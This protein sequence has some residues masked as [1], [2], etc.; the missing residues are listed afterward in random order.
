MARPIKRISKKTEEK[1]V[2]HSAFSNPRLRGI[3]RTQR[4]TE[5][6]NQW[7]RRIQ[8]APFQA[9]AYS[10]VKHLARQQTPSEGASS[11]T[12][13]KTGAVI[14]G[15]PVNRFGNAVASEMKRRGL[16]TTKVVLNPKN[17][18]QAIPNAL[19]ASRRETVVFAANDSD[20]RF[21]KI[22]D[23]VVESVEK[24]YGKSAGTR[25]VMM[26]GI[27]PNAIRKVLN[28]NRSRM[29]KFTKRTFEAVQHAATIRVTTQSGTD[30]TFQLTPRHRWIQDNGVISKKYW[31]NLP[32]G[33]V[34][35][36]PKSASGTLVLDGVMNNV[37]TLTKTPLFVS[38]QN[39]RAD[40]SSVRC[41]NESLRKRFLEQVQKDPN[42]S[43]IGELGLGTN[44]AVTKI[45][46]NDLVDE[47][48]VGVHIAFGDPEGADTHAKW[49]S[50]VHNDAILRKPTIFVD[51]RC[52]M[53]NGKSLL[54]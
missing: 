52:I 19:D 54:H 16:K 1:R 34:F 30:I 27:T 46:G 38:I 42:A 9:A 12:R 36:A 37:G 26:Y 29:Y 51:G 33:E 41:K 5:L 40:Y 15:A 49:E 50:D 24:R 43:R 17:P 14:F 11:N 22:A 31:G 6:Q 48:H 3:S 7:A 39:G 44:L 21:E 28:A 53:V 25:L 45:T 18:A 13:V 32:A 4:L 8:H 47:K 2:L 35:T 23:K 10:T 20:N